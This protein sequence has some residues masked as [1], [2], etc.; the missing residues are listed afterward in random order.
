MAR[1]SKHKKVNDTFVM[2]ENSTSKLL[3]AVS[4]R[5]AG[6]KKALKAIADNQVTFLYGAPGTGKAQPLDSIVYTPDG[7]I[8][9]GNIKVGDRVCTPDSSSARVLAIYPQGV[10]D[11][12]RLTFADGSATECCKEHLWRISERRKKNRSKKTIVDTQ[13]LMDNIATKLG[14]RNIYIELSNIVQFSKQNLLIDPYVLGVLIGDGNICNANVCLS[15]ADE[16]ILTSISNDLPAGYS[17]K[18]SFRDYDYR[19]VKTTL[20][21]LNGSQS[22]L[23]KDSLRLYGLWGKKS[24]EKFI[25]EDYIFSSEEQRWSILQ[26]LM[27]TD[28]YVDKKTGQAF[29]S[30]S[31]QMLANDIKLLVDSLGGLCSISEKSPTYTY[32]G[33]K[34]SGRKTY[35]CCLNLPDC[36]KAFRLNRKKEIAK[37][38]TK[39]SP[40]KR[41]LVS[42]EKIGQ[43]EAQ[44][45]LIDSKDHLYLTDNFIVTHNTHCA[46]GYGIQ[47]MLKGTYERVIFTRPYVEAG[48]KLGFLPGGFDSKFAPFV[49]PLYEVVS[50]YLSQDEIKTMI[51]DK[52]IIVYPLAY[53]RGA[54][55]KRSFIVADEV[56]NSTTQQM[57]MMLTRIGEGT[58]IVCTGD[59]EQSDLG[60]RINGLADAIGRLQGV[61]NL[62]FVELGYDSCVREK[63]VSD[64]DRRYKSKPFLSAEDLAKIREE[65]VMNNG[66]YTSSLEEALG[67]N[68]GDG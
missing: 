50:D 18:S 7:P 27:D 12:Y 9:M 60:A 61:E 68:E 45:I 10:K 62:E 57:R 47:E 33:E 51:E 34:K 3:V 58:K 24:Y 28:G 32:L 21:K 23:Y 38:K 26:G 48:E 54:T 53:M 20:H 36:S 66:K 42:V 46:V 4:A 6:Q 25:P 2:A 17:L 11:I 1:K 14:E 8:K 19:I 63:I 5:N 37:P 52:R 49:M 15:S 43:K 64:I 29:F 39:Y 67:D 35:I 13:Y 55:F 41:V 30:T 59:V 31:S 65:N 56:Q 44:C 40:K 16:E 22:N